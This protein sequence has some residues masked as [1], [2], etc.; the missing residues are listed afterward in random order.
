LETV[1]LPRH[2]EHIEYKANLLEDNL[3]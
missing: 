1:S 2:Q 3:D